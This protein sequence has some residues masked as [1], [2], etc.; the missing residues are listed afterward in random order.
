[1]HLRNASEVVL[2]RILEPRAAGGSPSSRLEGESI[3]RLYLQR[4]ALELEKSGIRTKT[5]ART[6]EVPASILAVSREEGCSLIALSTH[7]RLTPQ[8]LPFGKAAGELLR[9]SE[10]PVLSVP[11]RVHAGAEPH[12]PKS[13]PPLRTV[14]VSSEGEKLAEAIVPAAADFTASFGGDLAVL[15]EVVPPSE[16]GRMEAERHVRA[17]EHLAKM[18]RSFES[19]QI[20]TTRVIREGDPVAAILAVAEERQADLIALSAGEPVRGT[21]SPLDPITEGV[22]R[23]STVPVLTSAPR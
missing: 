3:A 12:A 7:G 4:V 19:K 18:A 5:V 23:A 8:S 16:S 15:L 1:M 9:S 13:G 22:L 6:G 17:E 2:V 21:D 14:L 11:P 10:V 20:P